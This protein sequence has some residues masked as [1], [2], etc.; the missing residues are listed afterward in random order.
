MRRDEE[1][2]IRGRLMNR[3]ENDDGYKAR[4]VV[5][6]ELADGRHWDKSYWC[7]S[8]SAPPEEGSMVTVV[9]EPSA[10]PKSYTDRSGVEKPG[11]ELQVWKAKYEVSQER[12][13]EPEADYSD[14]PIPF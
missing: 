13:D 8:K 2:T 5:R 7:F 1:I 11:V 12:Q 4:V 6:T 9:G 10:K 14:D 3:Y